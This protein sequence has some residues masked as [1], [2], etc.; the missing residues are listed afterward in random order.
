MNRVMF[1]QMDEKRL[2]QILGVVPIRRLTD[3][4]PISLN[5]LLAFT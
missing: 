2:R 3:V 1:Q 4:N 5:A